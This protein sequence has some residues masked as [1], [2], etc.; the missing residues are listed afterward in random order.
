MAF[1]SSKRVRKETLENVAELAWMPEVTKVRPTVGR[2]AEYCSR[3]QEPA[4]EQTD[5]QITNLQLH[6]MPG[7]DSCKELRGPR[8]IFHSKC[9]DVH[10]NH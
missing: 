6:H 9:F 1:S 3:L 10:E 7:P 5:D 2:D 8:L 4:N